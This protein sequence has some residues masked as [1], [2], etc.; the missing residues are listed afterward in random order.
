MYLKR[1]YK[2]IINIRSYTKT[3]AKNFFGHDC[4]Y[5]TLYKKAILTK[6]LHSFFVF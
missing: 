1:S 4:T 5:Y 6:T 3:S 2:K